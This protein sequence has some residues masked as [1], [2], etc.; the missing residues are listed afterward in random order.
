MADTAQTVKR[1]FTAILVLGVPGAGK[2]SLLATF[3]EYL[4]EQHGKVLLLYS[5]DGGALPTHLQKRMKQGLIRFWRAR[6]RSA[7]GLGIETLYLASKGYWPRAI[8]IETGETSPGVD[9]VPPVTALYTV[10]C[11]KTG[12]QLAALPVRGVVTPTF[13]PDCKT[14]HPLG[15]LNVAEAVKRTRGFEQVGGVAFDGLTSMTN[16]VLSFMDHSRGAG[17]VGGEKSAFGGVIISGSVKLGGTNRADIGLGQSRGREFVNNS[18]SIPYLVEG[19]V[20]TALSMEA[21]DEGGLPIVGAKLPGRA[22]TDEASSWFGNVCEMGKTPDDAGRERFTLFLRPFTDGQN[23]RHLLKTSASPT[24]LPDALI[25]PVGQPW[26]QANLG[27]VFRLLDADL[28]GAM[29]EELPDAPSVPADYG[30]TFSVVA[31]EPTGAG[32]GGAVAG[33][34][35]ALVAPAPPGPQGPTPAAVAV[36]PPVTSGGAPLVATRRRTQRVEPAAAATAAVVAGVVAA[37][38]TPPPADETRAAG[39]ALVAA[40]EALAGAALNGAPPPPPGMKPPARLT[41]TTT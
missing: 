25:D 18:L 38:A 6:T 7:E 35:P 34:L 2:T 26:A 41:T 40:G 16:E 23:R 19:P 15:E 36:P 20:F 4:W 13:C 11:R 8:N 28:A 37:V 21:T 30:E 14:I 22:A 1:L 32:A 39:E 12:A 9:L 27:V 3:A 29:A 31:P 17:Q 5:W 33:G 10:S 24:G